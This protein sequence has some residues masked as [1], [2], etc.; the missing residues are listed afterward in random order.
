VV[1]DGVDGVLVP[2]GDATALA[3]TLRDLALAPERAAAL[4]AAAGA[5]A[6]RYAWPKVAA[7]VVTAYENARAVPAPQGVAVRAAVRVGLRSADLGPRRPA[8]RLPSLQP[9]PL[10]ARRAGAVLR[11]GAIVL[12]AAGAAGGAYLALERIGVDRVAHALVTSSPAWVLV[13]LALM[14]ASMI[15]RAVSWHAILKAALPEA[16]PRFTDA[17]QGTAVGVLMSATLPARLGEPSRAL[18]VA[19]R[20]G[21]PREALPVVDRH[22]RVADAAQRR[23]LMILGGVMF[24]TIGLFAGRQQALVWYALAPLAVLALVLA[25]PALARS[26]LATALRARGR[27][28]REARASAARVRHGLVVFRRLRM[29][30]RR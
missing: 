28:M 11:R 30:T 29:G 22:A 16:G 7:Q 4:G 18:I 24:S 23:R 13:G 17:W 1:R 20:L 25:A 2:R 10:T 9:A 3:E 12:A 19:R 6:A 14:C 8:Q 21:R 27:W 5:S 15:F 26:G